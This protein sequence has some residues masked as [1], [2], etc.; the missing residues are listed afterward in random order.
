MAEPFFF[1]TF[2]LLSYI[3]SSWS[4]ENK[5]TISKLR[6]KNFKCEQMIKMKGYYGECIFASL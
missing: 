5:W 2:L 3:E 6:I 4:L 1:R